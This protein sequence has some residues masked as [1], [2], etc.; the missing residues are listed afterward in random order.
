M[1]LA[2]FNF[3]MYDV[4]Q[5]PTGATCQ[6]PLHFICRVIHPAIRNA[7]KI[8]HLIQFALECRS[9]VPEHVNHSWRHPPHHPSRNCSLP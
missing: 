6:L 9:S 7:L 1:Q 3:V 4:R 5:G 8:T 2:D